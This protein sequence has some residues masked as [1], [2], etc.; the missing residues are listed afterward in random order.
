[1]ATSAEV[2]NIA[3]YAELAR[4]H[5]V[6]PLAIQTSGVFGEGLMSC[7]LSW[8]DGLFRSQEIRSRDVT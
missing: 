2:K 8:R 6:T 4:T 7:P 1:M 3:K 5:H